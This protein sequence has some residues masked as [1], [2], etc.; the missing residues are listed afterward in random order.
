[1]RLGPIGTGADVRPPREHERVHYLQDLSGIPGDGWEEHRV[2]PGPGHGGYIAVR[3]QGGR[4]VP[5][6]ETCPFDICRQGYQGAGRA[7][8]GGK[9]GAKK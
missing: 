8:R 4:L 7:L 5:H 1:V 3:E 6:A 2:P 9:L